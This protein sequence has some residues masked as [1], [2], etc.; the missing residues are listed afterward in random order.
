MT[1]KPPCICSDFSEHLHLL[2]PYQIVTSPRG[3]KRRQEGKKSS[4]LYV[5]N[6]YELGTL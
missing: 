1:I 2:F 6:Y 4:G 5:T 3:R